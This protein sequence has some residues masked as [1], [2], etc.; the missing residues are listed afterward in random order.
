MKH[1]L[2]EME[3]LKNLNSGLGQFCLHLGKE[4]QKISHPQLR[5]T[6]YLPEIADSLFE[7]E[8][9]IV[10]QNSLHKFFPYRGK[11]Y[12]IWHCLH[13]DSDYLP[14]RGKSKLILTIHDL[15]FL[16]KYK[17]PKKQLKLSKLQKKVDRADAITVIS[18]FTEQAVLNNLEIGQKKIHL[19]TNGNPLIRIENPSKP[20]FIH[21]HD[22]LFSIGIISKKKNFH[23]LLPLLQL[24]PQLHLVIAGIPH[25]DYIHEI[26][27]LA[28]QLKIEKRVLFPGAVNQEQKNWLYQNCKAFVFPSLQEGF[29]L[30]VVEAMSMGKPVF[31]SNRT[32]LPEVGGKEAFYWN[33]FDPHS[34]NHVLQEGL[35]RF[36]PEQA[37]RSITWSEQFSWESSAKKYLQLYEQL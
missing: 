6:Y 32:S 19:I 16:E 24:N 23:V 15:N 26:M 17:G 14:P 13:Q 37:S 20:E 4:F 30:P 34:M 25:G 22:F 9:E 8:V 36:S 10:R 18:R 5:I 2:V 1:V 35:K 21:F 7:N 31:I 12:D 27:E 29:G 33:D 11:S 3:K 28:K